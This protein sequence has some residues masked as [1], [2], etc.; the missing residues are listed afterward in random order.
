MFPIIS[1]LGFDPATLN[2][3]LQDIIN[4]LQAILD[5]SSTIKTTVE[6]ILADMVGEATFLA[7][8]AELN[9]AIASLAEDIDLAIAALGVSIAAGLTAQ[10]TA[11]IAN[12]NSNTTSVVSEL[13]LIYNVL[14]AMQ[15]QITGISNNLITLVGIETN[16]LTALENVLSVLQ[17]IDARVAISNTRLTSILSTLNTISEDIVTISNGIIDTNFILDNIYALLDLRLFQMQVNLDNLPSILYRLDTINVVLDNIN[18]SIS[19]TN[20][21][22]ASNFSSLFA[23]MNTLNSNIQKL[24]D[25]LTADPSL[26]NLYTAIVQLHGSL[27]YGGVFSA[28]NIPPALNVKIT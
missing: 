1:V 3:D 22:L 26:I 25:G 14:S 9:L 13:V 27:N 21:I 7:S 6:A 20:S 16:S 18:S 23:V 11:L 24:T 12:N 17:V 2:T 5:D 19:T 8:I 4:K 15:P 10:T 28:G